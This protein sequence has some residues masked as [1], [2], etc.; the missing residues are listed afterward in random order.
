MQRLNERARDYLILIPVGVL[1]FG[2]RALIQ[3]ERAFAVAMSVYVFYVIISREWDRRRE[4]RFWIVMLIFAV[5][6]VVALS[7]VKIPHYR[8]PSAAI[9]FPFMFADGFAMWGILN[10]IEK[11]FP[12][13]STRGDVALMSAVGGKRTMRSDVAPNAVKLADIW[14]GHSD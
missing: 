1:L 5:L 11:R 6:H 4:K 3:A 9:A 13:E 7:L 10:W 2:L 8:G 14:Q 12:A